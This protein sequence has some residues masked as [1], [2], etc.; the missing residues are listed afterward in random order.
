MGQGLDVRQDLRLFDV[1]LR[2]G[3]ADLQH[4]VIVA[5]FHVWQ[6]VDE[7]SVWQ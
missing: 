7:V 5:D 1:S 4:S 3:S 6:P 2:G